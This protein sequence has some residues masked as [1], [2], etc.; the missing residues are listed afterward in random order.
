VI[1]RVFWRLLHGVGLSGFVFAI[2]TCWLSA[3]AAP[4]NS[5]ATLNWRASLCAE[6]MGSGQEGECVHVGD[7]DSVSEVECRRDA[8]LTRPGSWGQRGRQQSAAATVHLQ[9]VRP[10]AAT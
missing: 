8:M 9:R 5:F 4:E 7:Y 1:A 6:G 3:H 10:A 2:G